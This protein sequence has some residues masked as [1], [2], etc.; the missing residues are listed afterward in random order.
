MTRNEVEGN[1]T[2]EVQ[3]QCRLPRIDFYEK[4]VTNMQL[5]GRLLRSSPTK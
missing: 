5:R 4:D 2:I 1:G 3:L